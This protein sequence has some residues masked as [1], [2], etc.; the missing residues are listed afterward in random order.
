MYNVMYMMCKQDLR[1][2]DHICLVLNG[3]KYLEMWCFND[4]DA[5]RASMLDDVI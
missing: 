5:A 1:T 3:K 2:A 4:C